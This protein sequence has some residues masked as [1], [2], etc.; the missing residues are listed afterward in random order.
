MVREIDIRTSLQER[1]NSGALLA[2]GGKHERCDSILVRAVNCR[3]RVNEG[4]DYIGA[5]GSRR[6]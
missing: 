5:T 1:A 6:A 4:F 2:P 3:T